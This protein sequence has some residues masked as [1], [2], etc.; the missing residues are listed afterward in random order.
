VASVSLP[1]INVT[2][3][4][5]DDKL[6]QLEPGTTL[7]EVRRLLGGPEFKTEG[8]DSLWRFRVTDAVFASDPYEIYRAT[9][10]DGKLTTGMIL[11]RG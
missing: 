4:E 1:A 10:D 2:R 5:L 8:R 7:P 6:T 9:F 11:P 3:A